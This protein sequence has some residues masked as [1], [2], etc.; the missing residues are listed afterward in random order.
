MGEL[1][2]KTRTLYGI[3]KAR[4]AIAKKGRAVVVEG[5]TDVIAAHAGRGG[6]D[7]RGDGDGDHA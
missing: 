3:D 6:G 5:Y 1:F 4:A 2:H 7:G